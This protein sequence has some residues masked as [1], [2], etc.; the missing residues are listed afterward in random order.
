MGKWQTTQTTTDLH[1]TAK[2]G[3]IGGTTVISEERKH[4]AGTD[5]YGLSLVKH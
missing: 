4:G 5:L 2:V 3:R 1:G